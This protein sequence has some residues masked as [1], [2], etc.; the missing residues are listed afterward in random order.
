MP[1]DDVKTSYLL[2]T[3]TWKKE[4][5][6]DQNLQIYYRVYTRPKVVIDFNKVVI[7]FSFM[8]SVNR[9]KSI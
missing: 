8:I 6:H 7:D 4:Q 2:W 3:L 1:I 5:F 9:H